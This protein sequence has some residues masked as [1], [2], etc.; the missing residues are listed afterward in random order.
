MATENKKI[1][2][3]IVD[4]KLKD[5]NNYPRWTCAIKIYTNLLRIKL[6]LQ[7]TIKPTNKPTSKYEATIMNSISE[8]EN[9]DDLGVALLEYNTEEPARDIV[10][11]ALCA[12]EAWKN[13]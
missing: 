8:W 1:S 6:M 13:L 3:S 10:L 12:W 5:E 7:P 11:D 4:E 2:I 9:A